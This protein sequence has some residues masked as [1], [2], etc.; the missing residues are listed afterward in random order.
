MASRR[1]SPVAALTDAL[2]ERNLCEQRDIELFSQFLA[3]LL[4]EDVVFVFWQ[5][6]RSKPCHVLHHSEDGHVHLVVAIHV[7]TLAGVG[8]GNALRSAHN[9]GSRDGEGLEQSE[10]DVAGARRRVEDEI[11]EVAPVGVGDELLQGIGCHTA[12]PQRCGVGIH[13]ESDAQEL[14]SI[15]LYRLDELAAVH[16]HGIRTLVLNVKHLWHRRTEDVGVEQ[17]HL[18]AQTGERDGEV[19]RHGALAHSALSGAYG[20]DVFHLREQLAHFRARLGL[21]FQFDVDGHLLAGVVAF[22][23]AHSI[24]DGSLGSLDCG[25]QER[26]GVAGEDERERHAA[27]GDTHVIG[28]HPALDEILLGAWIR[29][30]LQRI[31]NEFRI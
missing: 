18:V 27:A 4:A 11:V 28:E 24:T 23:L 10:M 31:G 13:E 5:F 3:A 20:D 6:G 2:H 16:R 22:V 29:H 21:I 1:H 25:F 17:S 15:F 12:S 19:C 9:H 14:H 7:D 30:G 26:V 8:E